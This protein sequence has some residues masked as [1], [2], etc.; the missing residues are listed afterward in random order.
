[1]TSNVFIQI[2]IPTLKM[3]SSADLE[4]VVRIV[5]FPLSPLKIV[6]TLFPHKPKYS[7]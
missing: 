4:F 6:D 2:Q 1:M 3:A 5:L 7:K